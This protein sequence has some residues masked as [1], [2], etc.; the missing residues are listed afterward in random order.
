MTNLA[1]TVVWAHYEGHPSI[2]IEWP[3]QLRWFVAG[4]KCLAWFAAAVLL[5]IV[6]GAR[7]TL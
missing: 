6:S 2:F 4:Y 7:V 1:A 3:G 5:V